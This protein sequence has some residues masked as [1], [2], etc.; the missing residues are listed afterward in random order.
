[1]GPQRPQAMRKERT[2]SWLVEF[3]HADAQG[4]AMG[5]PGDLPNLIYE[6]RQW[7][8]L[9]PDEPVEAAPVSFRADRLQR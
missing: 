6:L 2:V 7:L 8:D 4:L 5:R 1:M 3:S 9:E